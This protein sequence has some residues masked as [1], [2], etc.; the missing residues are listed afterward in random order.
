VALFEMSRAQWLLSIAFGECEPRLGVAVG[1][2][3]TKAQP[4]ANCCAAAKID[5]AVSIFYRNI[6]LHW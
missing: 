2:R 4:R 5:R 6:K 1:P 3:I